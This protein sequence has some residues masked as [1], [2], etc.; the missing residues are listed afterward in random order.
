MIVGQL[1]GPQELRFAKKHRDNA[2]TTGRAGYHTC[3]AVN[4]HVGRLSDPSDIGATLELHPTVSRSF[5]CR[6]AKF[7]TE[8]DINPISRS[9]P[10][11]A[12]RENKVRGYFTLF[13]G[14]LTGH[15]GV[16]KLFNG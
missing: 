7:W 4:N 9:A 6:A 14:N 11:A 16:P 15:V 8:H 12:D 10:T 13:H 2:I 3:T 1:G 5:L